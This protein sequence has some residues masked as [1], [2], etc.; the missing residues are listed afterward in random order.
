MAGKSAKQQP[1]QTPLVGP[2]DI[3]FECPA[4]AK[5]LVIHESATGMTVD[6]PQCQ[7]PIIVPPKPQKPAPAPPPPFTP[8]SA[9]PPAAAP[10][11][12]T[13][14]AAP[15]ASPPVAAA[16]KDQLKSLGNRFRELQT[17]RTELTNRIASRLNEVSRDMVMLARLETSQQQVLTEW[18]QVADQLAAAGQSGGAASASGE[19]GTA[20]GVS[21]G[22]TRV[23]FQV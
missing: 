7:I 20:A 12:K 4:C 8:Q 15:P 13:E 1:S 5:S 19:K 17:Q 2:D 23:T 9:S 21:S 22:R 14:S 6:C 10:P 11:S 16:L 3:L 18:N